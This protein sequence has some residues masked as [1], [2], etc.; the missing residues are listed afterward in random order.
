MA[1]SLVGRLRTELEQRVSKGQLKLHTIIGLQT[2]G[3]DAVEAD[4]RTAGWPE[5]APFPF[6]DDNERFYRLALREF[7]DA[8]AADVDFDGVMVPLGDGLWV[9]RRCAG[10]GD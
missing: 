6:G 9:A 10:E 7:N 1:E 5:V 8:L 3:R 2:A 4:L